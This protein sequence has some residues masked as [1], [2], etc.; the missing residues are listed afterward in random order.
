MKK[1]KVLL[2]GV[3]FTS[4]TIFSGCGEER[5]LDEI[6][7]KLWEIQLTLQENMEEKETEK[8][9]SLQEKLK[10]LQEENVQLKETVP[11]DNSYM[12]YINM[13]FPVD[14]RYY[15]LGNEEC[16]IYYNQECTEQIIP[17]PRFVSSY[18]DND[19]EA[20]NGLNF[21][22]LRAESGLMVYCTEDPDLEPIG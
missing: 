11:M 9:A 1:A 6:N 7:D 12:D 22:T 8:I 19:G 18:V 5:D 13:K 15:V 10:K 20:P 21:K 17:P 2:L 14:G 16:K 3:I 4:T